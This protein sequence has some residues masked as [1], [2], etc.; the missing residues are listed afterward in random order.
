LDRDALTSYR[1]R[2]MISLLCQAEHVQDVLVVGAQG[3]VGMYDLNSQAL[4]V[5]SDLGR[6]WGDHRC[7]DGGVDCL[8]NLWVGSTQMD[9]APG[10]GDLY[11]VSAGWKAEKKIEHVSISNGM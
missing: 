11:R 3:G 10:G 9:H 8:G 4:S 1:G 6:D 2:G 7:N 5:V